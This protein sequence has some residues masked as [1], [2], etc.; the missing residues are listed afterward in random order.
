MTVIGYTFEGGIYCQWCTKKRFGDLDAVMIDREKNVVQPI[1]TTD[2]L[3]WCG[4][5]CAECGE[6]VAEP[7]D[8]EPASCQL[9]IDCRQYNF[10]TPEL[11]PSNV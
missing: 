5:G 10:D 6:W 2:E 8:H 7:V 11:E 1:F 3:S 9:G 4:E